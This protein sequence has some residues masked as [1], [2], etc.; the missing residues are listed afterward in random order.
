MIR[1]IKGNHKYSYNIT[2]QKINTTQKIWTM[3]ITKK[4]VDVNN[5]ES[6]FK[7]NNKTIQFTIIMI[8]KIIKI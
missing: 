5:K 6:R 8:K 4:A 3:K 2:M 7:Q 1:Q